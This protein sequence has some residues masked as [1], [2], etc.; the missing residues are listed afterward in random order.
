VQPHAGDAGVRGAEPPAPQQGFAASTDQGFERGAI[1]ETSFS[2]PGRSIDASLSAFYNAFGA[3]AADPTS[4]SARQQ[5]IARG[6][7]LTSDFNAMARRLETSARDADSELR[8]H[9]ERVN[10]LAEAIASLNVAIGSTGGTGSDVE[11]LKDRQ[12]VALQ[13]LSDLIDVDV[14]S[15]TDGGMDVSVGN[16]RALVVGENVYALSAQTTGISGQASI[17]S[18]TTNISQEI[19]GGRIGGLVQVRDVLIPS[20]L[21]RLDEMA[22]A[23][24]N[25]VNA[26]HTAGFDLDGTAGL[27]FFTPPSAV[28]GAAKGLALNAAV[29][30]DPRRIAAAGTASAGD[31]GAARAIA[32]LQDRAMTGSNTRPVEAWGELVFR[33]GGD[34]QAAALHRDTQG[35][36]VRQIQRLNEEITGV[37]LDEEAAMMMRFQRAYEA[38]ARFFSAADEALTVLLN[39]V[40]G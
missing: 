40:R 26:A 27:N 12:A 2:D 19:T 13:H 32:D 3:L 22:F 23:V 9:V 18:G 34:A 25:D 33:V 7:T 14:I 38:N 11:S 5:V 6:S 10:A 8:T 30:G 36:V 28:A 39:M 17:F 24:A 1:L 29:A 16:G 15:R 20:Y 31:N 4:T 37:S 35:E 21:T